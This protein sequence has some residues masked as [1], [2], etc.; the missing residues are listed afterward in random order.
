M[1]TPLDLGVGLLLCAA[2]DFGYQRFWRPQPTSVIGPDRGSNVS[3]TSLGDELAEENAGPSGGEHLANQGT[4]RALVPFSGKDKKRV[5]TD[6]FGHDYSPDLC[7]TNGS[8]W[9]GVASTVLQESQEYSEPWN[10]SEVAGASNGHDQSDEPVC[11]SADGPAQWM[12][13]RRAVPDPRNTFKRFLSG[14]VPDPV[15]AGAAAGKTCAAKFDH[16]MRPALRIALL[17]LAVVF[18][19]EEFWPLDTAAEEF[20]AVEEHSIPEEDQSPPPRCRPSLKITPLRSSPDHAATG[21]EGGRRKEEEAE[22]SGWG[23]WA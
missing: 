14:M 8:T 6:R 2:M 5:T 1:A 13:L 9:S 7:A 18:V 16:D 17:L 4:A 15:Y 12:T 3:R 20:F 21:E 11:A 10:N 23:C 22:A 19:V